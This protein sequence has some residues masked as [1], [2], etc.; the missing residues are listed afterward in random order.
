MEELGVAIS[1]SS[2]RVI[3]FLTV[4]EK[5]LD[6]TRWQFSCSSWKIGVEVVRG[7][8]WRSIFLSRAKI[9]QLVGPIASKARWG[10]S[11]NLFKRPTKALLRILRSA[12]GVAAVF[13]MIGRRGRQ[14]RSTASQAGQA[15]CRHQGLRIGAQACR[16]HVGR[17]GGIQT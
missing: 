5:G 6:I 2:T 4:I 3:H 8:R 14:L 1:V 17:L 10:G 13:L 15:A 11:R 9:R 12:R 7:R 16:R